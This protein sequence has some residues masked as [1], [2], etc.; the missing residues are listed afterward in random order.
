MARLLHLPG[1]IQSFVA[2]L[3]RFE[4]TPSATALRARLE[5]YPWIKPMI[6]QIPQFAPSLIILH[7]PVVGLLDCRKCSR[8]GIGRLHGIRRQFDP[9]LAGWSDEEGDVD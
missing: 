5:E 8:C 1:D 6:E 2:E 3:A 9:E 4:P 7:A